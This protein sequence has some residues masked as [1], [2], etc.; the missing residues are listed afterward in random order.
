MAIKSIPISATDQ[1]DMLI[2][3]GT[4]KGIF[5]VRSA[6]HIQKEG[7]ASNQAGGSRSNERG[8]LWQKIWKLQLPNSEKHFLWRACHEILP[9]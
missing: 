9:T 8:A 5:S 3:R 6:Y 4:I 1:D 2:W 7:E